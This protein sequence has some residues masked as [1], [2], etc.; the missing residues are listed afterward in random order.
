MRMLLPLAALTASLSGCQPASETPN[1]V[2]A[3]NTSATAPA[4]PPIPPVT[5]AD[6][7]AA[8]TSTYTVSD[9]KDKG[10]GITEFMACFTERTAGNKCPGGLFFG[11]RD[12]FRRLTHF[13]PT[14]S[15]LARY[16]PDPY[17]Q[18]YLAVKDCEAPTYFLAPKIFSR[19]SW[20]FIKEVAI[21]ADGEIVLQQD[22]SSLKVRR[23]TYPGGIEEE[24]HF[25]ATPEQR[26]AMARLPGVAT[27][28]VRITGERGFLSLKNMQL[29]SVREEAKLMSAAFEK[30]SAALEGRRPVN[31]T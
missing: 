5:L 9:I 10:D 8:L 27:L 31:C 7:R 24:V 23:D 17:V 14:A 18:T 16:I 6:W 26:R 29:S 3:N 25:A 2:T 1:A 30:V 4:L 12:S 15:Q 13:T 21:L 22:F 11:R 28:S 19:D 20:L